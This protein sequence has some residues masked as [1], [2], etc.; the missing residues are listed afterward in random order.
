M[1]ACARLP[2]ETCPLSHK[3]VKAEEHGAETLCI[4]E[5]ERTEMGE[6]FSFHVSFVMSVP[7]EVTKCPPWS[8]GASPLGETVPLWGWD[9]G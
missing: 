3:V 4:Q 8:L 2:G 7:S 6:M 5:I 1:M 9:H